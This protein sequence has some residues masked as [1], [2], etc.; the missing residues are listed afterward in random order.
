MSASRRSASAGTSERSAGFTRFEDFSGVA[1]P[2][3]EVTWWGL[4]L[5]HIGNND[6]S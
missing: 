3:E 6:G 5:D 1:G 2:I 4:D